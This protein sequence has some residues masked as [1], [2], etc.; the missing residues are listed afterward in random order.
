MVDLSYTV[1]LNYN[2]KL[3]FGLKG[4]ANLLDVTY[5]KLTI[6]N[7]SDPIAEHDVKNKFTP[8]VG[9][10]LFLYSD[11]AYIG[12]SAPNMLSR[13]RYNDNNVEMMKQ[14]VNFY[15]TG[16]YVF[17]LDR[18]WK[19]KPAAMIKATEGAPLQVDV[20]ANFMYANK[21]IFGAAYRWDA[22]VSG[23]LGFQVNDNLMIGYSYDADTMKLANYN[24]GSHEI[25]LK[26]TL[27]KNTNKRLRAPR[28][29]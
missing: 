21:F 16:G 20:S 13:Q 9:A 24:S 28:F 25:F 3:S 11:K 19:F 8:N 22:S 2:Y 6:H 10:G 17:D 26:F 27:N 23:L 18:D 1:D 14:V 12:L 15:L 4:S 7:P 29:F 5:S